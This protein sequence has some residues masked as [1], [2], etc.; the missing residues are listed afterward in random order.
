M[1]ARKVRILG[2][3][4]S[5]KVWICAEASRSCGPQTAN[6]TKAKGGRPLSSSS[7]KSVATGIL[8]R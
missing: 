5:V 4:S 7:V 2:L 6:P 3:V 1:L 8:L